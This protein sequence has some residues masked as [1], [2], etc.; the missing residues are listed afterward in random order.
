MKWNFRKVDTR[1]F[2]VAVGEYQID[3][4]TPAS[5]TVSNTDTDGFIAAD[6]VGFI[7][8]KWKT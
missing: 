4:D 3:K 8:V 1:E 6:G 7:K 2:A 5:V